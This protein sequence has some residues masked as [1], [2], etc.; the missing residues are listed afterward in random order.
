M[1]EVDVIDVN[2]Q[3]YRP[4]RVVMQ[5]DKVVIIDYKFGEHQISYENKMR[6]YMDIW[7]RM[8]YSD[9][10]AFLWYVR[11]GEVKECK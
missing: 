1:N 2:G 4:D 7:R 11:S 9:V 5:E 3:V 8:G 10:K 6:K